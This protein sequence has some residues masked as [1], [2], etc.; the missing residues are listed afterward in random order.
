M[1]LEIAHVAKCIQGKINQLLSVGEA[2]T[3]F[4]TYLTFRGRCV[5]IYSYNTSQR[6]ALFLKFIWQRTQIHY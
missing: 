3:I 6:D 5:V 2:V 4:F 1:S